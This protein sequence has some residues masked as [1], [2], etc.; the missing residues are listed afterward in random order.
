MSWKLI[1]RTGDHGGTVH[2]VTR[3]KSPNL[4]LRTWNPATRSWSYRSLGHADVDLAKRQARSMA[5]Q[6]A[7]GVVTLA[8][9]FTRY[10]QERTP[11][12]SEK[13]QSADR[14]RTDLW[15]GFLEGLTPAA[16]D[17]VVL[18]RFVTERR[19]GMI[20]G[21]GPVRART[22]QADVKWLSATFRWA[23]SVSGPD[24]GKL[25]PGNPIDGYYN[26]A[27]I[28]KN[29]RRPVASWEAWL[30]TYRY[31]DR[32]DS[33]GLLRPLLMLV[34]ALGWRV[35][36]VCQLRAADID[37]TQRP[38]GPYGRIHKRED[39]DKED[40]DQ[41]VPL[42]SGGRRA[43]DLVLRRRQAVGRVYLF[44]SAKDSSKP[45]TKDHAQKLH[46]K[47]QYL[48]G[49]GHRLEHGMHGACVRCE[50]VIDARQ[51]NWY[52]LYT[53]CSAAPY[54]G[55]HAY[56]RKWV[57]ERKHLP[58]SDVAEAGGWRSVRT[59]EL[60]EHTDKNTLL[61]VVTEP[62][63]LREFGASREANVDTNVNTG[64]GG[65]R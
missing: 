47:A 26:K 37:L 46:K 59:L 60:Y 27:M 33:Q 18:D 25:L 58:R 56:R 42:S 35:S 51:P 53:A 20:P 44:P 32:I 3:V 57:T 19:A 38:D 22:A 1:Y 52:R 54:Y 13:Q 21:F 16:V 34:E 2:V 30:R 39:S 49:A 55:W 17:R 31:A 61:R 36:A 48:A 64:T 41:W 29:V 9:I 62:G 50:A 12:K 15:Q 11:H 63:K 28:E 40:V 14:M 45:W 24:G 65:R 23:M 8:Y 5:Q 43:V 10:E 4:S 6:L 7:T